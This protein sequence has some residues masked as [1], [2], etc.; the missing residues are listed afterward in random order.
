MEDVVV[1]GVDVVDVVMSRLQGTCCAAFLK[2]M[3]R[4][5]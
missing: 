4:V 3:R 5:L 1:A 2:S